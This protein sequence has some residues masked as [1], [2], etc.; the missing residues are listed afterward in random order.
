[1]RTNWRDSASFSPDAPSAASAPASGSASPSAAST[2]A[3]SSPP[4]SGTPT[5]TPTPA[6]SSPAPATPSPSAAPAAGG[7][8]AKAVFDFD[9]IFGEGDGEPTQHPTGAVEVTPAAAA[10]AA[11][12][13]PPV[14]PPV[15][16]PAAPVAAQPAAPAVP[17]VQP[18]A[19]AQQDA[20]PP[21]NPADPRA[22]ADAIT[23]NESAII[24]HVAAS[25]FALTPEEVEALE[26]NA[27]E[28]VPR[29]MAKC[30]VRAQHNLLTQ[31]PNL[32]PR[33]IEAHMQITRR[34]EENANKFYGRWPDIKKGEHGSLVNRFAHTYRQMNP[35][36][37]LEQMVEDVGA[38]VMTAAKITATPTAPGAVA[39]AHP[40]APAANVVPQPSPFSPANPGGNG[41]PPPSAEADPWSAIL[42]GE[43]QE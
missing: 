8:P 31:L 11:P 43:N 21:L 19:P 7:E 34:N 25:V 9:T 28:A 1:M 2:P 23:A 17:A 40:M 22:L 42:S 29:L 36:A 39:L 37:T 35:N 5:A 26:T 41:G 13:V 20:S 32:V 3:A 18:S 6:S 16:A 15:A 38:M 12:T 27:V 14:V 30:L 4:A 33:M 24:D 10:A